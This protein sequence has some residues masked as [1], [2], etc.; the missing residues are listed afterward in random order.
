MSKYKNL[1]FDLDDTLINN[2]ESVKYA[3]AVILKYLNI[4]YSEKLYLKWKEFDTA[5][6]HSW[7]SG[8]MIIPLN[9][10]GNE[11]IT[12]LRANRFVRFFEHLNLTFIAAI[13]INQIYCDMLGHNILEIPGARDLLNYLKCNDYKIAIATNGPKET[14][15]NKLSKSNL[16]K[17]ISCLVCAEDVGLSKPYKEFFEVLCNRIQNINKKEMLIIGDSLTSDILFGM[18]NGIDSCWYN[19]NN[20][21]VPQEYQ[22]TIVITNLLELKKK[23]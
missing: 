8:Q 4:P 15:K 21:P 3:F 7:E 23:I 5:Y 14:T 2:D 22:P 6:W 9:L 16:A 11:K 17:Y 1:I 10:H 19:P 18:N 13:R 20:F 12:Y